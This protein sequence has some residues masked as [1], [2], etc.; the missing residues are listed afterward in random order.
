MSQREETMAVIHDRLQHLE[1]EVQVS[2]RSLVSERV[3]DTAGRMNSDHDRTPNESRT[4]SPNENK[5]YRDRESNQ[6]RGREKLPY[7]ENHNVESSR[8]SSS[9]SS[10]EDSLSARTRQSTHRSEKRRES[11]ETES[12]K[13]LTKE[14]RETFQVS[15]PVNCA[16]PTFRGLCY[17]CWLPGHRKV[18]CTAYN[19]GPWRAGH[20]GQGTHWNGGT[21]R[22]NYRDYLQSN[23]P[24]Y[25]ASFSRER[26]WNEP[27]YRGNHRLS[28][29]R[30]VNQDRRSNN[31][32][33]L[34]GVKAVTFS[35]HQ[36][37]IT[38]VTVPTGQR[39][40]QSNIT[41]VTPEICSNGAQEATLDPQ[42]AQ[43]N[44]IACEY[45][46][47]SDKRLDDQVKRAVD[48]TARKMETAMD[49]NLQQ[50]TKTMSDL[51]G[52]IA[53][54]RANITKILEATYREEQRRVSERKEKEEN[55]KITAKV[56]AMYLERQQREVRPVCNT[57][58]GAAPLVRVSAL[59]PGASIASSEFCGPRENVPVSNLPSFA[60]VLS[61]VST[62]DFELGIS[63]EQ[64]LTQESHSSIAI[65]SN[66][67]KGEI[68]ELPHELSGNAEKTSQNVPPYTERKP[69]KKMMI[70]RGT[71]Q[72]QRKQQSHYRRDD[73]TGDLVEMRGEREHHLV[74]RD[75]G[76]E[77][78]WI[79]DHDWGPYATE[80]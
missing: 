44:N 33:P 71:E 46:K 65:L 9:D 29:E 61:S 60:A 69:V 12:E 37:E 70:C 17:N 6:I 40:D 79:C 27:P 66:G 63:D 45:R 16:S 72:H 5:S 64:M 55:A 2:A 56:E 11:E 76:D 7:R 43:L 10:D 59:L 47:E 58:V 68:S 3:I 77:S 53:G 23:G 19:L 25:G 31:Y 18:F 20:H 75:L 38:G 36:S 21:W 14:L 28:D 30:C 39:G 48:E 26:N 34:T 80:I 35:E 52:E 49:K 51:K 32:P 41:E 73:T 8:S 78:A 57:G 4:C 67:E 1:R 15:L 62:T 42:S 13:D 22:W 50:Q 74:E 54:A 24:Q